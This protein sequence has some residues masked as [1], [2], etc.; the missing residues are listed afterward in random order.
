MNIVASALVALFVLFSPSV[1]AEEGL[2]LRL[3]ILESAAKETHSYSTSVLMK[4]T[5]SVTFDAPN[6]YGIGIQSR[7]L[8]P[9]NINLIFTLKDLSGG[10]AVYGGGAATTL[11]GGE[12]TSMDLKGLEGAKSKY[13]VLI[14]SSFAELP[15]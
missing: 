5:E 2:A 7:E 12:N 11:K 6:H 13:R 3:T 14:E 8:E 10:K 15:K 4:L 1:S 9:G